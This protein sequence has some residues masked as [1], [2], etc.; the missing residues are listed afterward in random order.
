MGLLN[1]YRFIGRH[2]L[3]RDRKVDALGR[4][5]RWQLGSR[6]PGWPV[7]VPFVGETRLLVRPGMTGATGKIY[8][9]RRLVDLQ[10][11]R[12]ASG[13]TLYLRDPGAIQAELRHSPR[14][15]VLDRDL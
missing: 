10:N 2:P 1:T 14:H 15:R 8:I 5:L 3:T 13:N 12:P 4:W 6:V 11:G 9:A 7:A